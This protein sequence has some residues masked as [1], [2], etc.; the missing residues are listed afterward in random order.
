MVVVV[1]G[2]PGPF[3]VGPPPEVP[4][5]IGPF[6]VGPLGVGPPDEVPADEPG[7]EPTGI[8]ETRD[9]GLT[10]IDASRIPHWVV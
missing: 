3:G 8:M 10:S 2:P 4:W 5:E 1:V 6:G 9:L 7:L